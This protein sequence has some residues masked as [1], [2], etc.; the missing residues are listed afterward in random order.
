MSKTNYVPDT[1]GETPGFNSQ[2]REDRV[3]RNT[4]THVKEKL[5]SQTHANVQYHSNQGPEDISKRIDA[6]EKEWS[7]DRALMTGAGVNVLIGL[8]LGRTVNRAWYI[9]PAV[10]GG[11]LIQHTLQGWCP[12]L[13]VFRRLGFRTSKEIAREKYALKAIRGDFQDIQAGESDI[14]KA[15]RALE[16]AI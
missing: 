11:F 3:R 8:L 15:A 10:V 4:A 12:P 9:F 5:D 16:A 6:L 1:M 7:I 13:P 14:E 2:D